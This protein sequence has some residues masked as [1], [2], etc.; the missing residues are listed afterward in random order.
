[1]KL[2]ALAVV[3]VFATVF[4]ACAPGANNTPECK[5]LQEHI[6]RISPESRSRLEGL[7]EVEQQNQIDQLVAK[8]PVEDIEQCTAAE[9]AVIACMQ[10]AADI[11]AVRACIPPPKKG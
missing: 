6:F 10:K 11:A 8:V 4:G 2:L 3:I 5:R 1:M 7:S 9:P